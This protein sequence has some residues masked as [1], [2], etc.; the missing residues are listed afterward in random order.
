MKLLLFIAAIIFAS[1]AHADGPTDTHGF[2]KAGE[3]IYIYVGSE[4]FV[5]PEKGDPN[6][7]GHLQRRWT[8]EVVKRGEERFK[9][10]EKYENQECDFDFK[11]PES[12]SCG[13]DKK[14][15]MTGAIFVV[16]KELSNC[17]GTLMKCV[18]G[19]NSRLPQKLITDPWECE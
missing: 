1:N 10:R 4:I 12:Y 7:H 14:S 3:E 8:V 13:S 5:P 17:R 9:V 16:V 11:E 19:C 6:D 2:N 18:S 15:P